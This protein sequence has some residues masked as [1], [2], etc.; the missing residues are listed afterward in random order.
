MGAGASSSDSG[1]I[2]PTTTFEGSSSNEKHKFTTDFLATIG[3]LQ[4]SNYDALSL[5]PINTDEVFKLSKEE[6][7]IP[8]MAKT[9]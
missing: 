8:L 4:N 3:V 9:Q 1:S 7:A 5:T 6:E 2:Y